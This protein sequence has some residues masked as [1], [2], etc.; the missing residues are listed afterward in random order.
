MREYPHI[1]PRNTKV[2]TIGLDLTI[3][4][5]WVEYL[6][7]EHDG[8]GLRTVENPK[9]F[10]NGL[11]E[12]RASEFGKTIFADYREARSAAKQMAEEAA[13]ERAKLRKEMA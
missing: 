5:R 13:R 3:T 4:K 8:L 12:F 1:P 10:N 7:P 11:R 6:D 2:W 9:K